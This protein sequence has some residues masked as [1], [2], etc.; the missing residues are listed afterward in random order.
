[1]TI[2]QKYLKIRPIQ[3]LTDTCRPCLPLGIYFGLCCANDAAQFDCA[4]LNRPEFM[5]KRQKNTKDAAVILLA[6]LVALSLVYTA[7]LKFRLLFH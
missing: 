1:V 3:Y 5:E 4:D 6:W 7:Y 2:R